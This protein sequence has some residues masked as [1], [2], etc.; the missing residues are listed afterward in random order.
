MAF[1]SL[2]KATSSR[3]LSVSISADPPYRGVVDSTNAIAESEILSNA[4]N[5]YLALNLG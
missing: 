3:N 4:S 2:L 5:S 1:T